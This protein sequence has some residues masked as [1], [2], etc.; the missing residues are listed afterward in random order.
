M[1]RIPPSQTDVTLDAVARVMEEGADNPMQM[2]LTSTDAGHQCRRWVWYRLHLATPHE[3]L[4]AAAMR[5]QESARHVEASIAA[6]LAAVPG[7]MVE[8][9][10]R[11]T[12]RP[13]E[14]VAFGGHLLGQVSGII[15]GLHEAPSKAHVWQHLVV[16]TESFRKML[17]IREE[18]GEKATLAAWNPQQHA[19][20]QLDMH[21]LAVERHFLTVSTPGGGDLASVRTEADGEQATTIINR[22]MLDVIRSTDPPE[23]VAKKGDFH[24]CRGCAAHAICRGKDAT[25]PPVT[26]RTCVHC[27]PVEHAGQWL[28]GWY[29]SHI[30]PEWQRHVHDG[31]HLYT[32]SLVPFEKTGSSGDGSPAPWISYR[33]EDVEFRNGGGGYKSSEIKANPLVVGEPVIDAVRERFGAEVVG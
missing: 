6:R 23:G 1:A 12:G 9:I 8:A 31:C 4:T 20:A 7:V 13:W 15:K 27:T 21:F 29:G 5:R 28:C 22:I 32:P 30:P 33:R 19:R 26:C 14:Y 11:R 17:K 25:L 2:H 24:L 10:N 16:S 18:R 3:R